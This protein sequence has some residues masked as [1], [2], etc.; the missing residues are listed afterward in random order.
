VPRSPAWP[1][2]SVLAKIINTYTLTLAALLLPLGA[3][4]DRWGR[5][6]VLIAGLI[7]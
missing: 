7:Q 4:G 1:D 6:P 2:L 5:E 3:I